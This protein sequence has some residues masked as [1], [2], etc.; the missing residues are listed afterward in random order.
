MA[1]EAAH[2]A[3]LQQALALNEAAWWFA[4][5][6]TDLVVAKDLAMQ[7][8]DILGASAD[9]SGFLGRLIIRD[10]PHTFAIKNTLGYILLQQNNALKAVD[11]LAENP[12]GDGMFKRAVALY[13]SGRT[14][15]SIDYL[16]RAIGEEKFMPSHELYLLRQYITGEFREQLQRLIENK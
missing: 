2:P 16:K 7:A 14:A 6:G 3:S 15:E 4:I 1:I 11:V 12:N 13:A 5:M 10:T 8:L 9:G